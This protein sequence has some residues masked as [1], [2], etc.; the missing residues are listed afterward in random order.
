MVAEVDLAGGGTPTMPRTRRTAGAEAVITAAELLAGPGP[1]GSQHLLEAMA[2]VDDSLA[3]GTLAAFGVAPTRWRPRST[4]SAPTAPSTSARGRRRP[5]DG[6]ALGDGE[7]SIVLRDE[8]A[9]ELGRTLTAAVGNP[10]FGDVPGASPRRALASQP[11]R[12]AGTPR[13]RRPGHRT[14]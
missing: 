11:R 9:V 1:V 4:S 10:V 7:L 8:A 2:L 12:P 3:A 14:G 5:A 6:G 13:S